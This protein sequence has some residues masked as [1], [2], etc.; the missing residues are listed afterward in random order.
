[1]RKY[2]YKTIITSSMI[3]VF[4]FSSL[5]TDAQSTGFMESSVTPGL[6]AD[7]QTEFLL[8]KMSLKEKVGQL[9]IIE[10]SE[11]IKKLVRHDKI[12]GVILMECPIEKYGEWLNELQSISKTP[13]VV[14]VDGE[15]GAS[16]RFDTLTQFPRNMQM[17]AL[18]SPELVYQAGRAMA[19]QFQRLGININFAPSVDINNNP[20]NPA[21]GSRSFGDDREKVAA[22]GAALMHGLQDGG[23]LASAKHFPGH[24]DTDTDSHKALPL[25]PFGR[26]RLDSLEL[27]PFQRLIDEGVAMVMVGHL[28]VPALDSTGMPSSISYPIITKLLKEQMGFKGIVITDALAMKGVAT[29]VPSE[30]VALESFKAGSDILL[31]PPHK[32]HKSI[33]TLLRAVRRKEVPESRVDES[34]RKILEM[35]KQLGIL[36]TKPYISSE[37]IFNEVETPEIL[38]L[39]QQICDSSI[40]M[41]KKPSALGI[42]DT[43]SLS[44]YLDYNMLHKAKESM[45]G[46]ESI[47]L[48]IPTFRAQKN[49]KELF[50]AIPPEE[51][52]SFISQWAKEQKITLAIMDSPYVL[53]K[54]DTDAFDGI[55]ICYSDTKENRIAAQKV[56]SGE[57]KASGVLPVAAGGFPTG[58]SD[59]L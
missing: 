47:V 38:N 40:T 2:I 37:N 52:Y 17:G 28:N 31:M 58:Y 29:Y 15:W 59:A 34:V 23:T 3:M 14:S 57:M 5:R 32:W 13:L 16:M 36:Q 9:F 56:L 4:F 55:I 44:K 19:L 25:L 6:Q 8:S 1:M 18:S 43:L 35:K 50:T 21:I 42:P 45:A 27:Y 33:K 7:N 12:G 54:I 20:L 46:K 11:G 10:Y 53:N 51:I 49:N 39:I 48:R 24:G 22:Y 30:T 26:E 41:V